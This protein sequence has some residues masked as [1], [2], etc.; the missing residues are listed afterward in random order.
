MTKPIPEL[1]A[2]QQA[3]FWAHVDVRG[4]DE[5]WL[6]TA[7]RGK[8]GYGQF[9]ILTWPYSAHRVSM[10]LNGRD[11][12]ELNACHTCDNPPCC[13]PAHL[14]AG[15][16]KQNVADKVRKGRVARGEGVASAKLTAEAIRAIRNDRRIYREI[17]ADYGVSATVVGE[18][19]R[20]ISWGHVA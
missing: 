13:N 3:R 7:G 5:C 6:W 1:T 12:L 10:S 11:P 18:V 2:K 17:A 20:R 19:K 4:P 9:S 14:F 15:M 8:R 16:D